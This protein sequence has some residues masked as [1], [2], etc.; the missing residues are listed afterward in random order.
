[1]PTVETKLR[2]VKAALAN[3]IF[4]IRP[5]VSVIPTP[6][7][8][9]NS[10]KKIEKFLDWLIMDCMKIKNKSIIAIDQS[11]EKGFYLMK[12]YWRVETTTRVETLDLDDISLQE[13]A[14]FFD[15]NM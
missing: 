10:A 3:V 14:M 12:P 11:L 9:Y 1:M 2:K 7:G 8:N 4:G 15:P 13:A 5:I 6:S